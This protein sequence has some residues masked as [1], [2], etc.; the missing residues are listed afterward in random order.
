MQEVMVT[1]KLQPVFST[2][3]RLERH[4]TAPMIIPAM[5]AR[6]VS[7]RAPPWYTFSSQ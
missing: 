3:K 6:T 7:W 1:P 5:V 4:I 2:M